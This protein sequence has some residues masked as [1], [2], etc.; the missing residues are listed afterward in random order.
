MTVLFL[1]L[2]P[3]MQPTDESTRMDGAHRA[4]IW[5][6]ISRAM[7]TNAQHVRRIT[8]DVINLLLCLF[9]APNEL[10]PMNGN[11]K[12]KSPN[13]LVD[14]GESVAVAAVL[15]Q[16]HPSQQWD[17]WPPCP[18]RAIPGKGLERVINTRH[19][20]CSSRAHC[21]VRLCKYFDVPGGQS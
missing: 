8:S 13:E 3:G 16:C 17:L 4:K 10:A 11:R 15:S 20:V 14:S 7:Q 5:N 2:L 1:L 6:H 19:F 12:R 21:Y 18:L 9:G